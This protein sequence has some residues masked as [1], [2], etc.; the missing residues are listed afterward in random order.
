MP[1]DVIMRNLSV[2]FVSFAS[3]FSENEF[4]SSSNGTLSI[5]DIN[6]TSTSFDALS[7]NV[8]PEHSACSFL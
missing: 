6:A 4:E 1:E 5:F 2:Y 3:R 8:T 7:S